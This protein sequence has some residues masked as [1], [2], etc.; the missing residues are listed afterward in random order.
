MNEIC[1]RWCS[2]KDFFGICLLGHR[3][4]KRKR[5]GSTAVKHEGKLIDQRLGSK[6]AA[7]D[8]RQYMELENVHRSQP[9]L[10]EYCPSEDESISSS[11]SQ[12]RRY[13]TLSFD[14]VEEFYQESSL[15]FLK[16]KSIP[17]IWFIRITLSPYPSLFFKPML[18]LI[19]NYQK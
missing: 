6:M 5:K 15:W 12:R 14:P 4:N 10:D 19:C 3:N 7:E 17:R 16:R 1:F 8:E 13:S 9:L 2:I 18:L 11:A